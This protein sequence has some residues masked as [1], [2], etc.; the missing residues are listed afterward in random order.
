MDLIATH[1]TIGK[2]LPKSRNSNVQNDVRKDGQS[3][4]MYTDSPTDSS[5]D[6]P[7]VVVVK[8]SDV[9]TGFSYFLSILIGFFA[10]YLSWR[11]NTASDMHTMEKVIW[12]F[13]SF[14]FSIPFLIYYILIRSHECVPLMVE[15]KKKMRN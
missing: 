15:Y 4:E 7:T 5:S 10:V 2:I 12:A 11:C 13:L 1:F 3:S 9:N 6:S 8:N 14:I